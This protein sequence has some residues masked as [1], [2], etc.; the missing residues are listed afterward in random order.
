ML[1]LTRKKKIIF[2]GNIS[3]AFNDS[4]FTLNGAS[5]IIDSGDGAPFSA[6]VGIDFVDNPFV[7]T[8]EV[9]SG[10]LNIEIP[11]TGTG[12]NYSVD[13][14]DGTNDTGITGNAS[15][16]YA[17]DSGSPYTVS[18]MGDFPRIY[19]N[20][21]G[22]KLKIQT[23]EFWGERIWTS[24]EGAF[25]GATN[26]NVN[27]VVDTPELALVTS[28][29][30]MFKNVTGTFNSSISLWT[31]DTIQNM[32]S[33]F[34]GAT[35]FNHDLSAWNTT[36]VTNMSSMFEGATSFNHDLSAWNT[37]AVTN[38]SR[39]FA[40]ATTFNTA[41]PTT[42]SGWNTSAVVNM[43]SMFNG[44]SVFDQ[45][46]ASWDV[47]GITD[48]TNMLD[49]T[50]LSINNYDAT[51]VGWAAQSLQS[52]ANFGALNL[53]YCLADAERATIDATW[54]TITDLGAACADISGV[55]YYD[56]DGEGRHRCC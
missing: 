16:L 40:G 31:T 11:T 52:G 38:M 1:Q 29:D 9:T 14:G 26:L 34:A 3:F 24:F 13:W 46:L 4:A 12:Y 15:H 36:T 5:D 22:D 37:A 51:L 28:M 20:D 44:A 47:S 39:M 35:S 18:I 43:A 6:S 8:W 54:G 2:L 42:V 25:H 53:Y 30:S 33:V 23:V 49:N 7:T 55:I 21:T 41:L 19:F 48:A 17:D 45:D 50:A 32:T 56:E 27:A 10:D